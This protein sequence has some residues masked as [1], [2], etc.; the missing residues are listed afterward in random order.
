VER[1][2]TVAVGPGE[3]KRSKLRALRYNVV[4][5][6]KATVAGLR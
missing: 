4:D 3:T 6:G 2:T 1:L 5:V